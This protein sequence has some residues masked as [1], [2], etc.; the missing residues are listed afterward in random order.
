MGAGFLA[1]WSD[2]SSENETDYLH[3]FSRE[4]AIERLS[5]PGFLSVRLFR[6]LDIS[7]RSYFILYELADESLMN[8]EAYLARLNQPTAWSQRIMPILGNFAR[9]GGRVAARSGRGQGGFAAAL[10]LDVAAADLAGL[11]EQGVAQDRIAAVQVLATD[12]ARTSVQTSEKK[13]RDKDRSFDTL[14]VIEGLDAA[15]VRT[16]LAFLAREREALAGP[17]T[18]YETVFALEAEG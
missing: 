3:W 13:L 14:L 15:A 12:H 4:H 5:V 16:A 17:A 7:E 10:R 9:G 1:I 2:I 18:V 8:S 6:A 11:A